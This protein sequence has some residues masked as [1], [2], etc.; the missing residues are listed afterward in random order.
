MMAQKI[1]HIMKQR[2]Q[3]QL[4]H[5]RFFKYGGVKV[6]TGILKYDKRVE[7]APTLNKGARL[8]IN[9][10]NYNTELVAA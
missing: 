10:R 3:K 2:K 5:E 1:A 6:S 9:A 7:D 4:N 8:N